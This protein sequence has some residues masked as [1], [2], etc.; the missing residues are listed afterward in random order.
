MITGRC[1]PGSTE[2]I[3][4]FLR[5][6]FPKYSI[7]DEGTFNPLTRNIFC[8]LLDK[9]N[10]GLTMKKM[11]CPLTRKVYKNPPMKRIFPASE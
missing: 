9:T 1:Y 4:Y 8:P 3:F 7:L 6:L 11:F 10:L 5:S 2:D